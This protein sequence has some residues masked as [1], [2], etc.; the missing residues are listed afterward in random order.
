MRASLRHLRIMLALSQT[1]SVTQTAVQIGVSQPAVSAALRGIETALGA[2]MFDRHPHGLIATAAG[3]VVSLRISRALAALDPALREISPRLTRTATLAQLTALIAVVEYQSFSA[4]A[5]HLGLA[6]PTVHRA[7]RQFEADAGRSLFDRTA[8]GV[9][10]TRPLRQLVTVMRLA[11]RELD[12][13][14]ADLADLSGRDVGGVVI[15]AMPLARA[16]LLGP[17]IALFRN[18]WKTLPIRI[19]D[20]AYTD[21]SAALRRGEI[22]MLVGALRPNMADLTQETLL[23]DEIVIVARPDHPMTKSI[24]SLADLG[25]YSWVVAAQGAPARDH[26]VAMFAAVHLPVPSSLVE[27]GSLALLCDLVGRSDHLGF[28]S[29]LQARREIANGTLACVPFY[30]QDTL[31]PIGL[32]TRYDWHP[33]RAQRDMMD[34]LRTSLR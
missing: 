25:R 22:D 6:Q 27:T 12:Q 14:Q 18:N 34:A 33:T 16:V 7:V 10:A 30:P 11:L 24:P 17:A 1:G 13:A 28:V 4:A 23:Q 29:A 5:R 31:R 15:G 2:V 3:Q 8:Q 26:F 20:G 32:T 19:I 9:I 21:L